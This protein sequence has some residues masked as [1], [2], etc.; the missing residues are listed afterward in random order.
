MSGGA[1]HRSGNPR[2]GLATRLTLP[3]LLFLVAP[4]PALAE[5][6]P[7]LSLLLYE[8]RDRIADRAGGDLEAFYAARSHRPLWVRGDGSLDPA[9]FSL[10]ALIE[11]A[12]DDGLDPRKLKARGIGSALR[13]AEERGRPGDLARAEL[14]L[15]KGLADYARALASA[16]RETMTY[17]TAALSPTAPSARAV[18][19]QAGAARSLSGYVRSMGWMHPFYA[20]LREM[21]FTPNLSPTARDT[22]VRNLARIRALPAAPAQRYALVDAA[23][24]RLW[25]FENGRVVDTM[26]VVVG[27]TDQQTPFLAGNIRQA[28]LNPYWNVPQDIVRRTIAANVLHRGVGYLASGG[29]QVLSDWTDDPSVVDPK[30]VDWQAVASGQRELRV[31]QLPGGSNFMGKVKYEFPNEL[32]IYLHDTPDKQLMRKDERQFSSGCVRLEDAQRFGRWLLKK[33]LPQRVRGAEQAVALPRPVPVYITYLT[34]APEQG[35][36][37]FRTDPYGRDDAAIESGP[38]KRTR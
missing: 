17:E 31:R 7:G 26:K 38:G 20:P 19:D 1:M 9:A 15:S 33:P 22:I 29:Y 6:A 24:A 4:V 21:L 36:V 37:A 14:A 35:R 11:S 34:A 25:M 10:M 18:L 23:G 2:R 5:P 8:V 30:A 27:K 28:I 13:D 16:P 3:A 32:G 12:E